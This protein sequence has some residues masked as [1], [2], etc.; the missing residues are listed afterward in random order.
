[1]IDK[2]ITE[3]TDCGKLWVVNNFGYNS[4]QITVSL[5]GYKSQADLDNGIICHT[6]QAIITD[7]T[8]F[9]DCG[10]NISWIETTLEEDPD[11][12]FYGGV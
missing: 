3:T 8:G 6:K 12:P 9:N 11:S 4:S 5:N 2:N 1:M 7:V 10:D